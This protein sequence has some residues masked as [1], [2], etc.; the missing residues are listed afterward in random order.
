MRTS[1][2][3]ESLRPTTS[4]VGARGLLRSGREAR[5]G[6]LD[7]ELLRPDALSLAVRIVST[8]GS[9]A[10]IIC[11]AVTDLEGD[12]SEGSVGVAKY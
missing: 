10:S 8:A 3:R 1:L 9:A 6:V 7:M 2:L 11:L 12:F 5:C 4:V